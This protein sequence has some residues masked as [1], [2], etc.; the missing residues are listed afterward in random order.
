MS[1][2]WI[3]KMKEKIVEF[4]YHDTLNSHNT[5]KWIFHDSRVYRCI[6]IATLKSAEGRSVHYG[7]GKF[8]LSAVS[9]N[10]GAPG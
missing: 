6:D 4:M 5:G 1:Q 3:P 7:R 2:Y 8:Y 9:Q 10:P